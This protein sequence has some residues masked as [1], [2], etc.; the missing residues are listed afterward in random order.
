MAELFVSFFELTV[1]TSVIVLALIALAPLL[2]RVY[3]AKWKYWVWMILALRLI[4]PPIHLSLWKPPIQLSAPEIEVRIPQNLPPASTF[5]AALDTANQIQ[6]AAALSFVEIVAMFWLLGIA[7]FAIHQFFS[8]RVFKAQAV[9]WSCRV[10]DRRISEQLKKVAMELHIKQQIRVLVLK[11]ADTPMMMGFFK[12]LL[13][14]P[15]ED[16][17][18]SELYFILKHE[19]V[20]YKRH[21]I[22]Y[23]LLLL[24]ANAIHWYNPVIY[25][26][27]QEASKDLELSCDDEVAKDTSFEK[28]KQYSETILA[29]V[30][31]QNMGQTVLT[32][33]F[34]GGVKIMKERFQNILSLKVKRPGILPSLLLILSLITIGGLVACSAPSS[35]N[36]AA[37]VVTKYL[38]A[39]RDNNYEAWKATL[40]QANS[41]QNSENMPE[42]KGD[43]GVI[44]LSIHKVEISDKQTQHIRE[45]YTGSDLAKSYGWPDEYIAENMVAVFAEY[46]VD[47]DNT[48]VPYDEGKISQYF[49]LVRD[50]KDSP[51]LIWDMSYDAGIEN[52]D[53]NNSTQAI[54]ELS[55]AILTNNEATVNKLI[56]SKSVDINQKNSDGKYPIEMVLV[57][58]NCEMAEILLDAGANPYVITSDGET[59]YETVMKRDNKTLKA[60]FEKY[61]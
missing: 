60:I 34:Y 50:D 1:T 5:H 7:I 40:W 29:S 53:E 59:V 12:P 32:T 22:W 18:D 61:K 16:Y 14:L 23:K 45:T 8:Y 17:N 4:L 10:K 25:M 26:M 47:Y 54:D 52:A 43:L 11:K 2:N 19:L 15:D 39:K 30:H 44:S 27:F 33:H 55:E 9:R 36:D 42:K 35:G 21:D 41:S 51:W 46:T 58:G 24:A 6:N 28:R 37:G 20:H 49:Y 48:K 56:Q 31:K 57:M 38:E 3:I 13:L